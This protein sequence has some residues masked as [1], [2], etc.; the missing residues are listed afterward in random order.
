MSNPPANGVAGAGYLSAVITNSDE[1]AARYR[2]AFSADELLEAITA[3]LRTLGRYLTYRAHCTP[4]EA[5]DA[6]VHAYIELNYR[7]NTH[8]GETP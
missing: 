5:G 1:L 6:L 2:E 8:T 4:V 7:I 3:P